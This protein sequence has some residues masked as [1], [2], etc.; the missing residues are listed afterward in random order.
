MRTLF[1]SRLCWNDD[2]LGSTLPIK[3]G[4]YSYLLSLLE[5]VFY[6]YTCYS[7]EFGIVIKTEELFQYF[8]WKISVFEAIN[9]NSHPCVVILIVKII[10]VVVIYILFLF[11]KE[12]PTHRVEGVRC[13][14]MVSVEVV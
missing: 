6:R 10:N 3:L 4:S 8:D 14:F 7:G 11:I 9:S 12:I 5:K 1:N 13:K 2:I